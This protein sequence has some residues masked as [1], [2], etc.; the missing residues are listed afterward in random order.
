M[1]F[2]YRIFKPWDYAKNSGL[3]IT[4]IHPNQVYTDQ[5]FVDNCKAAGYPV[6]P[7]TVNTI[8]R[9]NELMGF[10][11]DGVFSNNPEIFT[12]V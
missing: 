8:D 11:V 1:L 2:Y 7:F 3:N 5:D 4:S 6:Y 12:K 9:F 10:G